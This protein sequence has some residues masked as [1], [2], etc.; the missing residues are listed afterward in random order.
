VTPTERTVEAL[1]AHL[2]RWVVEQ[3]YAAYT[4]SDQ[5]TWRTILG[6]LTTELPARAHPRYLAGL[7][8]TGIGVER[9][10][11]L[12]EMNEKLERF[13]W[14]AVAVAGFISPAAFTELQSRRVLAIAT[15]IRRPEHL[16]YTPAPDIVHESA[17]HAPLLADARY[18][19]YLQRCGEVSWRAIGAAED[20]AVFEA[21][22]DLSVVKE[23][24]GATPDQLA[25]AEGRLQAALASVPFASEGAR[26]GRL[27][28]WTAEYGLVGPLEAPK[29]YG[30]GLLSSLGEAARCLDPRVRKVRLDAGCAEVSFDI[31]RMQP[32]LFV[33]EDFDQLFTVLEAFAATLSF[34]RGGDHGLGEALRSRTVVELGLPG[35]RTLS[36]RVAEVV[37]AAAAV[38]PGL[39]AALV[40][41]DGPVDRA[42]SGPGPGGRFQG[43]ALVAFGRSAPLPGGRF[44]LQLET[45]LKLS[46]FHVGAGE[47]LQLSGTLWGRPLALPTWAL[48]QVAERLPSVS[49]GPDGSQ[50]A[51]YGQ[52][53]F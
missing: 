36:G 40:R 14:G 44:E 11:S 32:Q 38:A 46:G 12:D 8:S 52:P 37:P 45:G 23:D 25:L 21:V 47:V 28:W 3:D 19:E 24:A 4:A 20:R 6:R 30:A 48:L 18:A 53:R 43:P 35:G 16:D 22:R 7:A 10:P 27:Y 41:L 5:Q 49:G 50:A 39:S 17:G 26:A 31:T 1:P 29:L 2:R 9:I 13:G 51:G 42:G 34:R 15:A 33:A